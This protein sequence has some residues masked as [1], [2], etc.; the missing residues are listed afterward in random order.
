MEIYNRDANIL[1]HKEVLDEA[2][3]F[4]ILAKVFNILKCMYATLRST[5][6][7]ISY[8]D[9]TANRPFFA[10]RRIDTYKIKLLS[11]IDEKG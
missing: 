6:A 11:T 10:L 7:F 8:M 9:R 3:I 5:Q 2:P 4:V 1:Y